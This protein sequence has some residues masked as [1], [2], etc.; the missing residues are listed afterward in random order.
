MKRE[1]IYDA[2]LGLL[3]QLQSP[4]YVTTWPT[5]QVNLGFRTY[6]DAQI[7]PAIFIEPLKEAAVYQRGLPTKWK[8]Q[9]AVWVYVRSDTINLGI[10][11]LN[12][13][14]DAIEAILSPVGSNAGA[15]SDNGYVLTLNELVQYAAIQGE[16]EI[17]GGYLQN[18]QTVARIPLEILVA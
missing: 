5:I 9:A 4:P 16:V 17:S 13:F 10:Q 14:M 11:N 15:P 3:Q 7:Q 12:A 2:L 1:P 18:N 8:L 6:E